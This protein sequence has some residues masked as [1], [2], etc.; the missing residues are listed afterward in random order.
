[1]THGAATR[2]GWIVREEVVTERDGIAP[3]LLAGR[4]TTDTGRRARIHSRAKVVVRFQ[5]QE[6]RPDDETGSG[7]PRKAN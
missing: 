1:M 2:V 6:G 5:I 3:S 4:S 7:A